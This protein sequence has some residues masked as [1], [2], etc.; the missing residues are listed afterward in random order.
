MVN[1]ERS[2]NFLKLVESADSILVELPWDK[3]FEKDKFLQPDFTSL[4][5]LTFAH[6]DVPAGINI[7]NCK[8]L[9]LLFKCQRLFFIFVLILRIYSDDS[10]RQNEGYKNVSLG[11]VISSSFR[12]DKVQFLTPED[13]KLF[14][15]YRNKSFDV[16][17]GLHE[18]FGHGSGKLFKRDADGKFNFDIS[19]VV[20]PL[21]G[22][23]VIFK[24][25]S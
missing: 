16:Q 9:V 15:D 18:L 6:S 3:S 24:I 5:V 19:T 20:N 25:I 2:E 21:T 1:K 7:P 11:N 22:T 23:K 13:E 4:D 10:I 17:V 8:F 14:Q 12:D